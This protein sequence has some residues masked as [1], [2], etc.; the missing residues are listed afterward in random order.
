MGL[1]AQALRPARDGGGPGADP[2]PV[3]AA[4]ARCTSRCPARCWP[5]GTT[6]SS[7][8]IPRARWCRP[9]RCRIRPRWTRRRAMLAA[10]RNP[11]IITKALGRDPAAVPVLVRLAETLGA[12]VFDQ[13]H[14]YVNF[15]QDHALHG[16]FEAGP[17]SGRGGR[18]P[19]HRV[20]R[21][22]VPAVEPP[23]ARDARSSTW[24]WTRSS[25]LSGARLPRRPGPGGHPAARA[26]R[27]GGRGGAARGPGGG[28]GAA[29]ALGGRGRAAARGR[30][31][32]EPARWR[33]TRPST[34]LALP[35]D[36][37]PGGRPHHRGQRVRPRRHPVHAS[38]GPAATSRRRRR[39]GSGGAWAPRSGPSWPRPIKRDLLRG[40]RRLHLRLAHR[41]R[42]SSRAPTTCPSSSW[43]STTAR[44][45]R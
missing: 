27:A 33:P 13:F 34:C 5:S 43:S 1:R 22:V 37:G 10:A 6:P 38:R 9:R 19:G 20:G 41:R 40:R 24:A 16:G 28:G 35:R 36:R 8:P 29:A 30:G 26:G 7:T 42:T 11:I 18:D 4:R 14:T 44:G 31:R 25:P 17:H 15:P 32:Q 23:G 45:T 12:P 21:A 39:A 3:G 2:G